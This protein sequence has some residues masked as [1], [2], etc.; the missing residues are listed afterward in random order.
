MDIA[1]FFFGNFVDIQSFLV[2]RRVDIQDLLNRGSFER[3][4][5]QTW[6]DC[7]THISKAEGMKFSLLGEYITST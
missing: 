1:P 6:D 7:V 5:G 4:C 2:K 3:K